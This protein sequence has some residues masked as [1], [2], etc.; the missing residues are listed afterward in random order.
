MQVFYEHEWS[1]DDMH[2]LYYEGYMESMMLLY[3]LS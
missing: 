2:A 3:R 1:Y